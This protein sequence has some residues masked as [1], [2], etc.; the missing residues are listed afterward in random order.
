MIR[1]IQVRRKSNASFWVSYEKTDKSTASS[2]LFSNVDYL[3]RAETK[4]LK[5]YENN[6]YQLK[7]N[8]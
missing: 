1:N 3:Y 2:E 5:F 8:R 4:I 7:D 6:H